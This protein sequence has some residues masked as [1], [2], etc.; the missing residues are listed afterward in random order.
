M[1]SLTEETLGALNNKMYVGGISCHL[2]KALDCVNHEIL[3]SKLYST[4]FEI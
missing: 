1:F 4:D 3:L 2:T